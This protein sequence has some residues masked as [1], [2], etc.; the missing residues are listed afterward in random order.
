[1]AVAAGFS[2]AAPGAAVSAGAAADGM[3]AAAYLMGSGN[4]TERKR[5]ARAFAVGGSD[6]LVG[7]GD[8]RQAPS[9]VV[10]AVCRIGGGVTDDALSAVSLLYS[11]FEMRTDVRIRS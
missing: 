5:A 8:L 2:A 3:P 7:G 9:A 6:A 1:M 11:T 10:A 4:G